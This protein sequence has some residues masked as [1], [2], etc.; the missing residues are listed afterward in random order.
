MPKLHFLN[1]KLPQ[2]QLKA[3]TG[4]DPVE[5]TDEINEGLFFRDQRIPHNE[6]VCKYKTQKN[7]EIS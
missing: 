4:S 2:I 7:L 3:S 5:I 6:N 1:Q